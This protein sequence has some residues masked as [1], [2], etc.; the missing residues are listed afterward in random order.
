MRAS[1][2]TCELELY[3][4]H[5]NK[6]PIQSEVEKHPDKNLKKIFA[7]FRF[8]NIHMNL[9]RKFPNYYQILFPFLD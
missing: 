8:V 9:N 2:C 4:D 3:M 5:K 7:I 1:A 6:Y